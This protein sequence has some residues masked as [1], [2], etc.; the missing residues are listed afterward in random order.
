MKRERRHDEK[1]KRAE[2]ENMEEMIG[3]KLER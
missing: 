1:E 2:E 3:S